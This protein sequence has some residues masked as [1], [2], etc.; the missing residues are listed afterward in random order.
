MI[1]GSKTDAKYYLY[2]ELMKHEI[3]DDIITDHI[4][5][6]LYLGAEHQGD[7]TF[8]NLCNSCVYDAYLYQ[9]TY[10]PS[11]MNRVDESEEL[12][13]WDVPLDQYV[14]GNGDAQTC[15]PTCTSG[16]VDEVP[17]SDDFCQWE[18]CYVCHDRQCYECDTYE[19]CEICWE[20]SHLS[21]PSCACNEGYGRRNL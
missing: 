19:T 20:N 11:E 3:I 5:R 13:F 2:D 1:D 17:C 10:T 9:D 7:G 4:E 14:D 21:E 8:T 12:V 16:C 15:D 18:Y 6:I